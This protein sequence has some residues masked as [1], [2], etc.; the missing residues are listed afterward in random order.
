MQANRPTAEL[1]SRKY[2]TKYLAAFPPF[3]NKRLFASSLN[4]ELNNGIIV[5]DS[6]SLR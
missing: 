1:R 6:S 2:T 5:L 3:K 4:S